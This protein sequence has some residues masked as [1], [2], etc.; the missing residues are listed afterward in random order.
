MRHDK[1][2][3][4]SP[5]DFDQTQQSSGSVPYLPFQSNSRL[6]LRSQAEQGFRSNADVSRTSMLVVLRRG[7]SRAI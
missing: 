4:C 2:C 3:K 6:L 5:T 7:G 1:C